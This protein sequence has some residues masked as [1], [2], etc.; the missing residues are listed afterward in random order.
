MSQYCSGVLLS[1][2]SCGA[3]GRRN[4]FV[5]T[6]IRAPREKL[7]S[8]RRNWLYD[9]IL[10]KNI[11]AASRRS[12]KKAVWVLI[13]VGKS[14]SVIRALKRREGTVVVAGGWAVVSRL[15]G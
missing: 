5:S 14:Q 12:N 11:M 9:P 4:S 10:V 7:L 13:V 1:G 3:C 6:I 8:A 15:K 2:N